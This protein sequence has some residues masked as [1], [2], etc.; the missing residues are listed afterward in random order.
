MAISSTKNVQ[1]TEDW[2]EPGATTNPGRLMTRAEWLWTFFG[3][4]LLIVF[5][6]LVVDDYSLPTIIAGR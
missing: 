4:A 2:S 1:R 5:V 6:L 3:I